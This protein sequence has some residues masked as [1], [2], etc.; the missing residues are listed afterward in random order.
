TVRFPVAIALSDDGQRVITVS[1]D[2]FEA[3]VWDLD[4]GACVQ[5]LGKVSG[6]LVLVRPGYE[7]TPLALVGGGGRAIGGASA[8]T[9]LVWDLALREEPRMVREPPTDRTDASVSAVS[10]T[11][12][13][14]S[15]ITGGM[16]G[17]I[18]IWDVER[19]AIMQTLPA[20]HSWV[21]AVAIMPDGRRAVSGS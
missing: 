7:Q 4:N 15:G 13:G 5:R 21:T 8:R 11:A 3:E 19:G 14:R 2:S 17:T 16:D 12:D 20:H 6:M 1:R 9:L 18:T 10:V